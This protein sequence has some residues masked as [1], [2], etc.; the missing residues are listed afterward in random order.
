MQ[1]LEKERIYLLKR[2]H[3]IVL[4]LQIFPF[5]LIF[6]FLLLL[7]FILFFKK[8]NW[9][10]I[11]IENFPQILQIRLNFLLIFIFSL[12]LPIIWVLIFYLVTQYYLTYWVITNKRIISKRLVS[13]FN[14]REET[15]SLDK[16]QDLT[17]FVKGILP[18]IYHF[19]DLKIETAGE[20]GQFLLDQIEDPEIVKQIIFE[21][22][23]D[24]QKESQKL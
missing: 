12:F 22:Q 13:L 14:V 20:K 4:Q 24:Y 11:L 2:R 19:G 9:P 10:Q 21:A 18:S 1:L 16:I 5:L 6:F 15:I 7:I 3:P 17:V 23:I 8:L